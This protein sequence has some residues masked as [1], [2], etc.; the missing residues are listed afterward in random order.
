MSEK[1][2]QQLRFDISENVRLHTH[3]PHIKQLLELDLYPD[4]QIN[5]KGDHLKIEG[6]LRL[7]GV[8]FGEETKETKSYDSEKREELSYIIPVEITLPADRAQLKHISAE[9]E[10]F[11][12]QVLSP[13]ELQIDAILLIDGLIPDQEEEGVQTEP[14]TPSFSGSKAMIEPK[15]AATEDQPAEELEVSQPEASFEEGDSQVLEESPTP[16]TEENPEVEKKQTLD[17]SVVEQ[18]EAEKQEEESIEAKEENQ[19]DAIAMEE[20]TEQELEQKDDDWA[21]WLL[22]E[23]EEN[24]IS[25]RM[26]I[27]QENDSINQLAERYEISP[28][29][30]RQVNRLDDREPEKGEIIYIPHQSLGNVSGQ[31]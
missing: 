2:F 24:F 15:T 16:H 31:E 20:E 19:S 28:N 22:R 26:V 1:K 4:V 5:E 25:M 23:R 7:K 9:I 10:S 21:K 12:Y 8:Y 14:S 29:R 3:Q 30:I 27:V 18:Q 13:F 17:E 11:D 6:F